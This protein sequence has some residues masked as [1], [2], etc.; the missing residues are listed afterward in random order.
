MLVVTTADAEVV[1]VRATR[2]LLALLSR[3]IVGRTILTVVNGARVELVRS[4]RISG[5]KG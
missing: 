1:V 4:Q 2:L 5:R 3:Y